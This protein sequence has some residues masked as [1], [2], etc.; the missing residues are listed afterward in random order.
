MGAVLGALADLVL[1]TVVM[2]ALV[3]Y[4]AIRFAARRDE[5]RHHL[6]RH[7]GSEAIAAAE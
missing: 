6:E 5:V 7:E 1:M 2:I 3:A 4:E